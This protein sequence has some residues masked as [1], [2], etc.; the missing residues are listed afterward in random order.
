MSSNMAAR[1]PGRRTKEKEAEGFSLVLY[2]IDQNLFTE[3]H[4]AAGEGRKQLF[5]VEKVK[6]GV[7]GAPGG[8]VVECLPLVWG[9]GPGA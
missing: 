8:S 1:A 9:V 4:L 3:P 2:L 7:L 6:F 5:S